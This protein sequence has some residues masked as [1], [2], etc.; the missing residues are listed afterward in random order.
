MSRIMMG[1]I[2]IAVLFFALLVNAFWGMYSSAQT[3]AQEYPQLLQKAQTFQRLQLQ[4]GDAKHKQALIDKLT[5]IQ[6]PH[7]STTKAQKT[8]LLF[9]NLP[10]S[11]ADRLAHA[12]LSENATLAHFAMKRIEGTIEMVVEIEK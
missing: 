9:K 4:W 3:L 11:T 5:S 10:M 2:A 7:S 12:V 6:L 1:S 8:T